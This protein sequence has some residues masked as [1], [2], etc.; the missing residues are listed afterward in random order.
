[1]EIFQSGIFQNYNTKKQEKIKL[2]SCKKTLWY[3]NK[4]YITLRMNIISY[5]LSEILKEIKK[6]II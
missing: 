1:M 4:A 3:V 2:D 5:I 6:Y